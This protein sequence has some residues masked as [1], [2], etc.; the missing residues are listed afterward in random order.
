[1]PTQT[2]IE[3]VAKPDE[4]A[5]EDLEQVTGGGSVLT[6]NENIGALKPK[7]G[8]KIGPKPLESETEDE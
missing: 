7:G 2:K 4:L 8:L 3:D 1:M 6:N 5:N